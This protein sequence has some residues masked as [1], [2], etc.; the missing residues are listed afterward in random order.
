[1]KPLC[2]ACLCLCCLLVACG[3]KSTPRPSATAALV[4]AETKIFTQPAFPTVTLTP[5]ITLSLTQTL[6]P[7]RT[8]FP[9]L[10]QNTPTRYPTLKPSPTF[11]YA[12]PTLRPTPITPTPTFQLTPATPVAGPEGY[13]LKP[14]TVQDTWAAILEARSI[15]EKYLLSGANGW[16][17]L[18]Y[19]AWD[20]QG[21]LLT[22]ER[23][24]LLRPLDAGIR[25]SIAWDVLSRVLTPGVGD[26]L[27]K[28][29][30]AV[31]LQ[32]ALNTGQVTPGIL[33]DWLSLRGF[34]VVASF[35]AENLA[36][37]GKLGLVF[38]VEDT[39]QSWSSDSVFALLGGSM[40]QYRLFQVYGWR[41]FWHGSLRLEVSDYNGNGQPEI[42]V[43][44]YFHGSGSS[45]GEYYRI[46]IYEWRSSAQQFI[47][48][49]EN[50][51]ELGLDLD[52]RPGFEYT[53]EYPWPWYFGPP[54]ANGVKALTA[55]LR[56]TLGEGCP[57]LGDTITYLWNGV[58]YH[59]AGEVFTSLDSSLPKTCQIAWA[60][61]RG[62]Q[63]EQALAVLQTALED[64][65]ADIAKTWGPAIKDYIRLQLGMLYALHGQRQMA[66]Q[67]LQTVRD[68]PE[69]PEFS[70]A[71][72]L[73]RTFLD[74][75]PAEQSV[76]ACIQTVRFLND[77]LSKQIHQSRNFGYYL[78]DSILGKWGF[79]DPNWV[80]NGSSVCDIQA[81]FRQSILNQ[82]PQ[83]LD[84]FVLWLNRTGINHEIVQTADLTGDGTQDWIAIL[85]ISSRFLVNIEWP[86]W[87]IVRD[88]GGLDSVVVDTFNKW[89]EDPGGATLTTLRPDP[90]LL[91]VAVLTQ[92]KDLIVF[93]LTQAEQ[94][95]VEVLFNNKSRRDIDH[96][97]V[98]STRDMITIFYQG[99]ESV[100]Q[101]LYTWVPELQTFNF[102]EFAPTPRD[103]FEEKVN[104]IE[105]KLFSEAHPA[106]VISPLDALLA[107]D[108]RESQNNGS[109]S[110]SPPTI[111]PYLQYLL[112]LAYELT[113]DEANAVHTYWRI[114]HD[115]PNNPYALMARH[116][117][118]LSTP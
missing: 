55:Q 79:D 54:D 38:Q 20:Y 66:V 7:A 8:R 32:N 62:S 24:A 3:G 22:M 88:R 106:E 97:S 1:M 85:Q 71:S 44:T 95:G 50:V 89:P 113:G 40:G 60:L 114:W 48:L 39:Y 84:Q 57:D 90:A 33:K 68:Q 77:A 53:D 63:D 80:Y 37:D 43:M 29:D 103:P 112:G 58:Q 19:A 46:Y 49:A 64:G 10:A 28:E 15:V 56:Y 109:G 96:V 74:A 14:W 81:A 21:Y 5:S 78:H 93:R 16:P 117:L 98:D 94:L 86:V 101:Y 70:M 87:V 41:S 17:Y 61:L 2:L 36:G 108:I 59:W 73:A 67:A 26:P 25:D 65:S 11:T 76:K 52:A 116:K 34:K 107:G 30:F 104:R 72:Q 18:P 6:R 31:M 69:H 13:R 4:D 27:D 91:P 42:V 99:N 118:E 12:P 110:S 82:N 92:G 45:T 23:E 105:N 75:Y 9:T 115:Y 83:D 100:S 51:P 102:P 35:P 47:D 111:R